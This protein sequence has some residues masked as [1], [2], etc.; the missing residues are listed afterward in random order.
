MVEQRQASRLVILA[1][2]LSWA[3]A[4]DATVTV[5]GRLQRVMAIGGE[6]TGW[7]IKA[8]KPRSLGG[9][10]TES[11]EVAFSDQTRLE[12]LAGK[13]V[14]ASGKMVRRS[15]V[16]RGERAVLEIASIRQAGDQGP[17]ERSTELAGTEWLLEDLAGRGVLDRVEATLIFDQGR[18]AGSASCNRFS[19]PADVQG[20][21]VRIGPLIATR[22]ACPE[23]VMEQETR[24]LKALEAAERLQLRDQ[25]LLVHC[26]GLEKPLRF[27]NRD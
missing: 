10:M 2:C 15:G 4:Q 8:E 11:V 22:R 16:E 7:S 6:S 13:Q 19:G 24:Y 25:F 1:T 20:T 17:P 12:A 14:E 5:R 21:A 26:R 23:A 27:R 18:V 3:F 9:T